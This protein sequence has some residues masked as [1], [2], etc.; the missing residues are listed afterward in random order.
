MDTFN[1]SRIEF[2]HKVI[3]TREGFRKVP[4][5][6]FLG[7]VYHVGKLQKVIGAPNFQFI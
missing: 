7:K 2:F 4:F 6:I 5:F 3:N 1:K